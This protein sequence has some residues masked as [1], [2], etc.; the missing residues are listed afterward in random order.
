M[1]NEN[2]IVQEGR[3]FFSP[4]PS[5][6]FKVPSPKLSPPRNQGLIAGLII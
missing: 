3:V 6:E 5:S 4:Q 2:L 1:G